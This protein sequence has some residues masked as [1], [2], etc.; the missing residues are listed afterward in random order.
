MSTE[1]SLNEIVITRRQNLRG[2]CLSQFLGGI[3]ATL[4]V[5]GLLP[6][7]LRAVC[8][9]PQP[10]LVCAEYF[11][12]RVVVEARL[13]D[14]E[15]VAAS[16][17]DLD[18]QIYQMRSEKVLR[19]DIGSSFQV[20]DENSSGRAAFDWKAGSSYLLFLRFKSDRGWV[21][22]G[23]GASGPLEKQQSALREIEA[24]Q[25]RSGGI[26]QVAIGG[27][28]FSWSPAMAGAQVKAQGMQDTFSVTTNDKGIAEIHVPAGQYSVTVPGHQVQA[29]DFTYDYPEK[30]TIENGSCAQIQLVQSSTDQ[31]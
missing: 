17:A 22:D 26:I 11:D 3:A 27:N 29:Y 23:C 15:E 13:V 2:I 20:W 18:G 21:L 4:I 31:K 28:V 10:R 14:S 19:G 24:L 7:S 12:S 9:R 30:V 6:I 1:R 5:A 8:S 16:G 25:K